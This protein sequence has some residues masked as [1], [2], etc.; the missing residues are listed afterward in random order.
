VQQLSHFRS[1]RDASSLE[2][3]IRTIV[4]EQCSDIIESTFIDSCAVRSQQSKDVFTN[5]MNIHESQPQE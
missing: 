2:G 5:L 3:T 1:T 4:T